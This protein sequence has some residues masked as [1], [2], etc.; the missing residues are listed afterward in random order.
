MEK[1]VIHERSTKARL[2]NI[3]LCILALVIGIVYLFP[4]YWML[5]GSF[6]DDMELI[7]S[8]TLWPMSPTSKPWMDQLTSSDF[9]S[10]LRNSLLIALT[11]M[12]ISVTLGL[13]AA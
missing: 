13:P 5:I 8:I 3:M 10:S 9:F 7:T 4:V 12:T 1:V 2:K 6:K 11:A